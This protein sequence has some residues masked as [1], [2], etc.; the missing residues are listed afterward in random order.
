[1][2]KAPGEKHFLLRWTRNDGPAER[3]LLSNR[4]SHRRHLLPVLRIRVSIVT[5]PLFI[6][7]MIKQ[8]VNN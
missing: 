3:R 5:S 4:I 6:W 2:G 7:A 8:Y 1:M